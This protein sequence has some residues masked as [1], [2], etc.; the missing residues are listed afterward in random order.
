MVAIMAAVPG[1][2]NIGVKRSMSARVEACAT[3]SGSMD[4]SAVARAAITCVE[5]DWVRIK[6][7]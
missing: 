7:E 6:I 1:I 5:S 4:E 2:A 3:M